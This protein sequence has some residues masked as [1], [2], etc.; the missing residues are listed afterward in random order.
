MI[1]R[2]ATNFC[3]SGI[4]TSLISKSVKSNVSFI[5]P[6]IFHS[7]PRPV[8][9]RDIKPTCKSFLFCFISKVARQRVRST[10]EGE[11][12]L[13][14]LLD[15]EGSSL[16]EMVRSVGKKTLYDRDLR[17]YWTQ[18]ATLGCGGGAVLGG[19]CWVQRVLPSFQG[20]FCHFLIFMMCGSG[21]E[22][23]LGGIL[24]LFFL[25]MWGGWR[26]AFNAQVKLQ[27]RKDD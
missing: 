23:I 5:K 20:L 14:S 9:W 3:H 7:F 12:V 18:G 15:G 1:W 11:L 4:V 2:K 8:K 6:C 24:I 19:I 16:G 26:L 10:T 17:D 27:N 21:T 22:I 13:N 25:G